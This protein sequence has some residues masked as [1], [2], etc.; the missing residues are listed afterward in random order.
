MKLATVKAGQQSRFGAIVDGGFVDLQARFK[1]KCAD[2]R[3]LLAQGLT[4]EAAHLCQAAP[5][6][7]SLAEIEFL[8]VNPRLDARVFALGWSYRSHQLETGK[9]EPEF[10]V[11]FS[12]HP[13]AIVGHGQPLIY[14]APSEKYDYEG[15]IAIVIGK[16]GRN[17][18]KDRWKDYVAGYSIFM[19]GSARDFQKHSITAGKNFDSSSAF[20]PW[21]VTADEI[22]D[23]AKLHL[24]TRVNGQV[25]QQSGFD[26]MAWELGFLLNYISTVCQLEPGDVISTGTPSGVGA[27]HD[28]PL[29]MQVGDTVEVEVTGIGTLRNVIVAAAK[30]V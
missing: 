7:F 29:F 11:L 2:L 12:K 26:C 15:E 19:D 9:D 30:Q 22:G 20:G 13:Q 14:P 28:P 21:L 6:D 10:P 4:D 16:A 17:I 27:R 8:P 5:V 25:R 24:T 1:G 18:P 23:P 3:D